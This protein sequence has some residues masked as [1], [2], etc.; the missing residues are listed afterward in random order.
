MSAHRI[1]LHSHFLPPHYVDHLQENDELV[2][3]GW[4]AEG[5]LQF[6][7]A[8]GIAKSVVSVPQSFDFGDQA[9]TTAIARHVNEEARALLDHHGDR[10]AVHAALPLPDVAA[11]LAELAHAFDELQLDG[12]VLLF[13]HYDGVYLGD[14]AF[15]DLYRELDRRGCVAWVHPPARPPHP[16]A[17]LP[18][19]FLEMP[20]E[21][22]RAAA[23]LIYQGV[24]ER[25]PN[26]T[27]QLSHAGG[28]L[29]QLLFR[30]GM[31]Q[32]APYAGLSDEAAP[33]GPFV[34]ARRF[35]YDTALVGSEEQLVSLQRL[36]GPERAVFGTDYPYVDLLF[37]ED[38]RRRWP[39]FAEML[40][41]DGDPQPALARVFDSAERVLIER[42]NAVGLYPGLLR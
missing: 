27:W 35:V 32:V 6:M 19:H 3:L 31:L 42:T 10:F 33:A 16:S 13:T 18:G 14:P 21:T 20:F 15:E 1:D 25:Y 8:W 12:G 26:I 5:H 24:L 11:A 22:T 2:P 28:A 39:W 29:I 9:V 41:A 4:S 38:A 23:N 34:A 40:P 7:D 36:T 37:Q 30:L 17:P